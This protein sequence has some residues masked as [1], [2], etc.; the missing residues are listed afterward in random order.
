MIRRGEL[1][2]AVLGLGILHRIRKRPEA[3]RGVAGASVRDLRRASRHLGD[4]CQ[5]QAHRDA[6]ECAAAAEQMRILDD[7]RASGAQQ[8]GL[9]E[10]RSLD[11]HLGQFQMLERA[12]EES[13]RTRHR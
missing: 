5:E 12:G 11:R 8:Q 2:L 7:P 13:R 3:D 6:L 9:V 4:L 1:D 10:P